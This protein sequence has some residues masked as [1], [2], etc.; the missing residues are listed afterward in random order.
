MKLTPKMKHDNVAVNTLD[1]INKSESLHLNF[2]SMAADTETAK[3]ATKHAA[4]IAWT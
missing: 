1:V 2:P 3:M 4:T